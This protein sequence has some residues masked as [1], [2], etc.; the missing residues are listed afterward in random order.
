MEVL[1]LCWSKSW[2][3]AAKCAFALCY[4]N[5]YNDVKTQEK[6]ISKLD[7]GQPHNEL[8]LCPSAQSRMW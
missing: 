5:A 2:A 6:A 3:L 4:E 8:Y 1:T 7:T